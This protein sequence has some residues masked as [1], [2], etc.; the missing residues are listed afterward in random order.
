MSIPRAG[1]RREMPTRAALLALLAVTVLPAGPLFPREPGEAVPWVAFPPQKAVKELRW[2]PFLTD[3]ETHL[4][5]QYGKQYQAPDLVVHAHETSHGIHAHLRNQY[6][7]KRQRVNCFYVGQNQAA[8]LAEP[9]VKLSQV[10][11]LVPDPLRLG[12]FKLY[13]VR[14]Q[15]DW[16]NEPLYVFDEWVAYGNGARAGIEMAQ[17]GLYATDKN[18][19]VFALLELNVY[20]VYTAL[21]VEKHDRG[22]DRTPLTEFLAWNLKRSMALY[23]AGSRLGPFDW[24]NHQYYRRLQTGAEAAEV[25]RCLRRWYGER[26][27]REVMGFAAR[28]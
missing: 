15:K 20:A 25:R 9:N 23:H 3:L 27:C 12:R 18:D 24:D 19:A 21:A 26:W 4:P 6:A 2:G 5:A 7:L 28:E 10:A 1:G 13:L 17:K 11:A 22:Y 14:Q 8:V 16:E